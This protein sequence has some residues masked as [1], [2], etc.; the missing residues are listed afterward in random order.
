MLFFLSILLNYMTQNVSSVTQN[1]S[2]TGGVVPQILKGEA[3][4]IND[5]FPYP[6]IYLKPENGIRLWRPPATKVKRVFPP[7]ALANYARYG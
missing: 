4:P 6:L 5:S 2:L 3:P 1:A 7:R